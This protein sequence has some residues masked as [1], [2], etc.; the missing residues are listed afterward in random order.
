MAE[1][2]GC[3][4]AQDDIIDGLEVIARRRGQMINQ[5]DVLMVQA[6]IKHLRCRGAYCNF[7]YPRPRPSPLPQERSK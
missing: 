2:W 5:G 1:P 7:C 6:A 4:M 3:E